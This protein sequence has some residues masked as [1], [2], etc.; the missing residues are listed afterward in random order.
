[1]R[2]LALLLHERKKY[3]KGAFLAKK[4]SQPLWRASPAF[5]QVQK[6]PESAIHRKFCVD[7]KITAIFYE[8]NR[9]DFLPFLMGEYAFTAPAESQDLESRFPLRDLI[10]IKSL[11]SQKFDL[12]LKFRRVALA[13]P[14]GKKNL[15]K[16][17]FSQ[18]KYR[19]LPLSDGSGTTTRTVIIAFSLLFVFP[20]LKTSINLGFSTFFYLFPACGLLP[21]RQR[22][23][24]NAKKIPVYFKINSRFSTENGF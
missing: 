18:D 14:S 12:D 21:Q 9:S 10:K 6:Y 17:A 22:P 13:V 5:F 16:E 11:A 15:E 8:A 7:R 3:E 1:M 2:K 23:Q 24:T 4:R 20:N 19:V